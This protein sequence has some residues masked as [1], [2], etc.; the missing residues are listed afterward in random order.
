MH[1]WVREC[2]TLLLKSEEAKNIGENLQVAYRQPKNLQH[3]VSGQNSKF[4]RTFD[5][6]PGC[7]KCGKC[8]VAC[9]KI[10]ESKHFTSTNTR[11]TYR[12]K[13]YINCD[14][15]FV[16]YLATCQ[17]CRG[18]YVGKSAT[19]F[20]TRHSNH[21]Q[22]IKRAYG[23]LGHHYGGQSGCSYEDLSIQLIEKIGDQT[24]ETLA[25]REI[26]WQNQL[27]VY[28]QNG[29]RAHCYRKET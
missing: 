19:I 14:S 10:M 28:V 11:R 23:G 6:N 7:F 5:D 8:R 15:K 16:I 26:F 27:R 18:Q 2:K 17:K 24:L 20:K 1:Q 13:Q 9:P 12:I 3:I 25:K 29:G 4:Q 21:K 22:E